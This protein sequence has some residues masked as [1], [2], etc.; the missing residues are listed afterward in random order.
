M[1]LRFNSKCSFKMKIHSSGIN[2]GDF[3]DLWLVFDHTV[4]L[5]FLFLL[6]LQE[7]PDQTGDVF[8]LN[9]SFCSLLAMVQMVIAFNLFYPPILLVLFLCF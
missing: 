6:L 2:T 8:A 7:I 3:D 4:I 9:G 1:E 5:S